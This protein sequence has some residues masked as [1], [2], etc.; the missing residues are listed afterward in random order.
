MLNLPPVQTL[1]APQK[2]TIKQVVAGNMQWRA[3]KKAQ[4]LLLGDSF[5]NVYSLAA[6]GW[7]ESAGFAEHLSYA[8]GEPLDCIVRNSDAA[9]ATR[10]I[11]SRE[12][13]NGRDRLSDKKLVVWEFAVRELMFGNWKLLD[14]KIGEP[15]VSHFLTQGTDSKKYFHDLKAKYPSVSPD[16]F[17]E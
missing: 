17:P 8:M 9:F 7:G 2:I 10:E 6:M 1:Y 11:L 16:I 14:T 3:N 4:V 5:C 15:Q 13:A 12:L